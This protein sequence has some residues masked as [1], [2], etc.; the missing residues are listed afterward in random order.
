[1]S[2]LQAPHD[3][4]LVD[5]PVYQSEDPQHSEVWLCLNIIA[6]AKMGP[7]DFSVPLRLSVRRL[8][9]SESSIELL[10]RNKIAQIYA[11][12]LESYWAVSSMPILQRFKFFNFPNPASFRWIQCGAKGKL[13]HHP[14]KTQVGGFN[15]LEK[16][17]TSKWLHLPQGTGWK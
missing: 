8:S 11:S 1:M 4:W 3:G 9:S 14:K 12:S 16:D 5:I 7:G 6:K 17:G 10:G 2:S 13:Q 15:P